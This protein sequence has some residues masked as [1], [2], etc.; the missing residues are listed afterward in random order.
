M[1]N[2]VFNTVTVKGD[3]DELQRFAEQ[4]SKKYTRKYHEVK[5]DGIDWVDGELSQPLSFW[6]FVRPD[7]SILDEYWGNMRQDLSLAE[8]LQNKTNHWYDWN[9]RNWGCKWDAG[10][11]S[12]EDFG[13]ELRYDFETPWGFPLEAIEAMVAQYPTLEFSV[14]FLEEQGWGGEAMGRNGKLNMVKQ[15]DIPCTHEDSMENMGS[16]RCEAL[17]DDEVEWMYGDCPRKLELAHA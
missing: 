15:W 5:P 17:G 13:G 14:R 16:C 4:A 11:V 8:Q 10:D 9:I 1:P 2:W 12:F 3:L 7:E 6:N